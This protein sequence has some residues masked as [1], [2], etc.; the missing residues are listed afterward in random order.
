M[1][2]INNSKNAFSLSETNINFEEE[3]QLKSLTIVVHFDSSLVTFADGTSL[4]GQK[5]RYEFVIERTNSKAKF[6]FTKYT[7]TLI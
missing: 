6:D 3:N 5:I 4:T 7:K 2:A 1:K